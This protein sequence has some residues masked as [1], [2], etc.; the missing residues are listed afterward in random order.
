[1]IFVRYNVVAYLPD[2]LAE[3]VYGIL[4]RLLPVPDDLLLVDLPPQTAAERIIERGYIREVFETIDGLEDI[5]TRMLRL[6]KNG[7]TIID[8]GNGIENVKRQLITYLE[9]EQQSLYRECPSNA[10]EILWKN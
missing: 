1:M 10:S 5:Q 2:M 4:A 8:N 6:S 9:S 7:W 3:L